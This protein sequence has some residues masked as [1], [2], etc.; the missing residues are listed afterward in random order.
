MIARRRHSLIVMLLTVAVLFVA[1]TTM[2][3]AK[4]GV[5]NVVYQGSGK[6]TVTFTDSVKY[7][8]VNVI[9]KDDSSNSYTATVKSKNASKITFK[10]AGCKAGKTYKISIKGLNSGD[11]VCSFK[12]YAKS[13]AVK[14]AKSKSGA[15]G[16]TGVK[17][18]ADKYNGY[19]VW[20]VTYTGKVESKNGTKTEFNFTY[21][22]K[23][24]TGKVMSSKREQA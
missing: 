4:T 23:Q 6:V 8:D 20:R 2:A 10:I 3:M 11:A 24:Q 21:L 19:A 1:S 14:V 16:I 7:N 9:V 13:K 15:T 12:I 17:T 22:V 5:K 18:K